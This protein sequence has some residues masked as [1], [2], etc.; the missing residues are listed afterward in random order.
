MIVLEYAKRECENQRKNFGVPITGALLAEKLSIYVHT[1]TL[2]GQFRPLG[3]ELFVSS[4]DDSRFRL[5]KI[6][7]QGSYQGYFLATAGK[8]ALVAKN[9]LE[10]INL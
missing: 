2:Y 6:S 9:T 4:Y 5:F 1:H 7:N 8:G 3:C 10:N